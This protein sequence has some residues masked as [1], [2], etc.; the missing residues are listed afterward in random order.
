MLGTDPKHSTST[1]M[2]WTVPTLAEAQLQSKKA[3]K[4][5][6]KHYVSENEKPTLVRLVEG[7]WGVTL[8]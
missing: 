6:L 1:Y 3:W 8:V 2:D 5:V 4:R 7:L